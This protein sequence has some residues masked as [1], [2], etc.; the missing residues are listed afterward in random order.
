M[1]CFIGACKTTKVDQSSGPEGTK[2][3]VAWYTGAAVVCREHDDTS[4]FPEYVMMRST[5][6]CKTAT[7]DQGSGLNIVKD[8]QIAEPNQ[9]EGA[10]QVEF[11]QSSTLTKPRGKSVDTVEGALVTKSICEK[12]VFTLIGPG[13]GE[14]GALLADKPQ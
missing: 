8:E 12:S 5:V 11:S 3:H 7:A 1:M 2:Q 13:P 14:V 10:H 9:V 6:G 4:K